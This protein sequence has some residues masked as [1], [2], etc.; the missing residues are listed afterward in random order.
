[1]SLQLIRQFRAWE[2]RL[3]RSS[4]PCLA[5]PCCWRL[6]FASCAACVPVCVHSAGKA[7]NS[8]QSPHRGASEVAQFGCPP[9]WTLGGV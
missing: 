5:V 9:G 7:Q 2:I 1:M 8:R 3:S 6:L 4:L